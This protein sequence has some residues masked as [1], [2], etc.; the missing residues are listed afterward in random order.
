MI[1]Y[2]KNNKT[3]INFYLAILLPV[4][5]FCI[6]WYVNWQDLAPEGWSISVSYVFDVMFVL[7]ILSLSGKKN[8][9]GKTIPR[10]LI[11]RLILVLGIAFLA[12]TILYLSDTLVSPFKHVDLLFIQMLILA[13]II[14]ELV[15]RGA[16]YELFKNAGVKIWVNNLINSIL[17]SAS[18]IPAFY[19]LPVEFHPFIY[20]QLKYA[21][22]LGH[23]CAKSRERTHGVLEPI[24]LHFVF[25]LVFYLA[26]VFHVI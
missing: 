14:E 6:S 16:I 7:C 22:V 10:N 9:I 4:F 20:F 5:Y 13:P 8:Y 2:L 11:I 17:F 23:L 24:I 18:H 1:E 15:F 25:N 12:I 26:V 19:V 3:N 21:F